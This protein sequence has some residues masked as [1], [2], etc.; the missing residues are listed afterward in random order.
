MQQ[1]DVTVVRTAFVFFSFVEVAVAFV[2]VVAVVVVAF[3]GSVGL[4]VS[5]S[6]ESDFIEV[7]YMSECFMVCIIQLCVCR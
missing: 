3:A 2:V 1:V 6:I 4:K 7:V 5:D